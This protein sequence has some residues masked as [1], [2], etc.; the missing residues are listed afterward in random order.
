[1]FGR[2]LSP[3]ERDISGHYFALSILELVMK[4]PDF[5]RAI[6]GTGKY[7]KHNDII[8]SCSRKLV[9][10]QRTSNSRLC[11]VDA[12][13]MDSFHFDRWL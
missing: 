9:T 7:K 4:N 5:K 13:W 6:K 8:V 11:P 3:L 2:K 1:M 12:R 10:S